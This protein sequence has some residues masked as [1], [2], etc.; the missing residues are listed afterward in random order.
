MTSRELR[1]GF[2]DFFRGKEHRIMDSSPLKPSDDT[3]LFTSSGMQT[4]V[5]WFRGLVPPAA[6]RVATC[7]K[8]FRSDDVEEVGLTPVHCTFFEMLGNFSF[9]D[10]FKREA[11][12]YAWEYVTDVL[13]LPPGR[14]WVT[15]HPEDDESPGFW[16]EVAGV[17]AGRIV[18]DPTN[19]WGPVGNSGPCGPCSE[20]YLDLGE[21][22]GCGR[23][24]CGP[25][26]ECA[27]MDEFWNLVFQIYNKTEAGDLE[28]LPDAGID[29][30]MG[31][32][33][34]ARLVQGVPTIFDTDLFAPVVSAVIAG[35]RRVNEGLPEALD[36]DQ[37][38]ATRI[39]A[40]HL[41]GLAFLLADG[42][43]PSNEGAGYVLRRLIRRAYRYGR[44]LGVEQPFLHSLVPS[45]VG[46]MGEVYPELPRAE[47]RVTT[48]LREEEKQFEETIQRSYGP[49]MTAIER[50]RAA[51]ARALAGEEVFRLHDTYGL[52]KE[53][54]L[55]IAAENGLTL[56]EEG[57]ERAMEG[58]RQRGRVRAAE[59]FAFSARSGYQSFVGGTRFLGYDTCT[60]GARVI[61]IV[62]EGESVERVGKG[63]EADVLLDQTPFYAEKGGQ[64]GDRGTLDAPGGRAEVLDTHYPVEEAHAHR[65]RVIE[66][67]LARD[68]QVTASVD[69]DRR[70]AIARA[71]T[72]THLLHAA[73][74]EVLGEHAAQSGSLVD[75]DRL[76]FDFSHFAALTKEETERI[77]DRVLALALSDHQLAAPEMTMREARAAGAIALFGEKYGERVRVVQIGDFSREL[78]GGTH[79]SHSAG[80]MGFAIVSE[81]SIGA[82]L[83][84]IEAV[85]GDEAAALHRRQSALLGAAAARFRCR[86]EEVPDRVRG[87]QEEVR[88]AEREVVRLQQRSAGAAAEP[89]AGTAVDVG[90]VNVV[91]SAVEGLGAE[92]MRTLAD[93]L[94]A[95]LRSG[96]VVLGSVAEGR[97][98][99]VCEVSEDLVKA[100]Y[101]AGKLV[102]E[103]AREAGGGGGGRADFAQAGGKNPERLQAALDKVE[104]LVAAQKS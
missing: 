20:V 40:D 43:T 19:W 89:L 97:V 86:P 33:R 32:E 72:A 13:A 12:A 65:V 24:D 100:G 102:R 93:D 103:V 3:T 64:V 83:R 78:C 71:H 74:R 51:G 11:I 10:Y 58:Q 26:C 42:F 46:V 9:G 50:A 47:K 6:P 23:P 95:R 25:L 91:A 67:E 45:V 37:Q 80:I 1:Q 56:D 59:D 90:G 21:E 16:R 18:Q 44:S 98:V 5:P 68:Q 84:R 34:L 31:L 88:K 7:Q 36:E 87:L 75:A 48:W 77:E 17:P 96:I 29:T 85:T 52:P 82:G 73:L 8:C 53:L 38:R 54:A 57:F 101:H 55:E 39:I 2:L 49:L 94:Q 99:F 27:R 61:G 60:A 14:I 62:R 15:V 35:A 104:E 22:K 69:A 70:Q 41:R 63:E 30:G 4:F 92:A 66:G 81:G 28:P 79:L 76:R